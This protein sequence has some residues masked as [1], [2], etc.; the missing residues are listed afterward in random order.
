MDD[1]TPPSAPRAA[2]AKAVAPV[3]HLRVPPKVLL[4][5]AIMAPT[6]LGAVVFLRAHGRTVT[7]DRMRSI[8]KMLEI[9]EIEQGGFPESLDALGRRYAAIPP[10]MRLDGWDRPISYVASKPSGP[11]PDL[12]EPVFL[13]C[14]LRSAGPNGRPGDDDD[15]VWR[16][17][18]SP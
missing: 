18:S 9:Y 6:I 11:R 2:V 1:R 7:A 17:T 5:L 4:V 8:R 13:E 15:V 3:R 16:G 10:A 12:P 14:E